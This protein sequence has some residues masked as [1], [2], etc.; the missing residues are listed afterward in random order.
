MRNNL[1]KIIVLFVVA[2]LM[3][4]TAL[5]VYAEDGCTTD[6]A[7]NVFFAGD[8]VEISSGTYFGGFGAGTNV[9]F[10]NSVAD[11]SIALAGMNVKFDSSSAVSS[12][13]LAGNSVVVSDSIIG[14]NI[15]AAGA[16]VVVDSDTVSKSVIAFGTKIEVDGSSS[17]LTLVGE[18]VVI[19][20][21][22]EGDVTVD[23]TTVKIG[24][25]AVIGGSAFITSSVPA[26]TTVAVKNPELTIRGPKS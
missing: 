19:N 23:A 26:N 5:T 7:G 16:S 13:Y 17:A 9:S 22:V 25:N 11:D 4:G 18:E 6:S 14:G 15:V 20:G 24:E 8:D 2:I 1:K 21:T 3:M 10:V 12:V